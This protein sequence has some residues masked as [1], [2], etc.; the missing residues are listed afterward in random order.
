MKNS[1]TF[2]LGLDGMPFSFLDRQFKNGHMPQ[3]AKLACTY[4]YQKMNSVY[5]TVS[6]VAWTT[7]ATGANPGQH[8]IFGFVDR[9]ADPFAVKIPTARDRKAETLWH[10]LSNKQKRVIVI[11]VPLTYPPEPVNGILIS[12]FLC[13]D[14]SDVAY[15][16]DM[17]QYLKLKNYVI[18]VDAW[19]ARKSKQ[20]FMSKLN[21]AL[22]TRFE[23]AFELME[24]E[25]WDFFQLH[26]METDR[27]LHFFWKDLEAEG[28]FYPQIET[29][30]TKLDRYIG[31]L[32]ERLASHNRLLILSDHGFCAIKAEVQLN[33]WLEKQG[34]LKFDS[35]AEKKLANYARETLC[36][37]LIPGRVYINLEGREEKGSVSIH[38]YEKVRQDVRQRLSELRDPETNTQVVDKVFLREEI[39]KGPLL[40]QAA[41][42]I[43]HPVNGYDLKATIDDD[44]LFVRT[45]LDGMHTYDD[46]FVCGVNMDVSVLESI[47]DVSRQLL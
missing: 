18:D 5:P 11:N 10:K 40:E 24:K 16:Q 15:P 25:K 37:A 4:G 44:D 8:G 30:F 20:E 42:L 31:K 13:T 28:E 27:L 21:E 22:E 17:S 6:S 33:V 26:I 38:D 35:N 1:R 32:K 29:F 2:V 23:I 19:L 46:A 47:Q 41:D 12:G 14:I 34:F 36:Y 45:A 43:V 39:Y 9:V 7:Y 3:F